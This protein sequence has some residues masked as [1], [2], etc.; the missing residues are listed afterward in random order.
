MDKETF[1]NHH[2]FAESHHPFA[3]NHH[4]F[5][6]NHRPFAGDK[7]ESMQRRCADY[8]YT[9]SSMYM[10]TLTIEGRRP[11]FGQVVGRSD[12][13]GVH[14]SECIDYSSE[15][16]D[17]SSE[18]IDHSSECIDHSS[19]CID[20]SSECIDHSSECIDHSSE[21]I[22]HSDEPRLEPSELGRL[23]MEEW[24]GIPSYYPQIKVIALQLMPDH[25]HGILW[26]R[27]KLP[28]HLSKVIAGFKTGCNRHYK[29]LYGNGAFPIQDSRPVQYVATQS[30]QTGPAPQQPAEASQTTKAPQQPAAP[31]QP[32]AP[33]PAAPRRRASF[34]L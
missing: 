15:C 26:V 33:Q 14:S 31:Q 1:E 30:Q 2:P 5:A 11:L 20:H 10:I 12:A 22:V 25:L 34:F 7:K 9:E 19:E 3:E 23:V 21:C 4:P 28:C 32:V 24:Y 17:H 8:D 27:E 6:E 18:C 13:S 29:R 16:I